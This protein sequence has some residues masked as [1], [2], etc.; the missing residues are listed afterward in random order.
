MW[1]NCYEVTLFREISQFFITV[2]VMNGVR[3]KIVA[4]AR[5]ILNL[6]RVLKSGY[7]FQ[8]MTLI[9]HSSHMYYIV[10]IFATVF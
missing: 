1:K 7:L 8:D 10:R 4:Y 2:W 6:C 9:H 5:N 3:F